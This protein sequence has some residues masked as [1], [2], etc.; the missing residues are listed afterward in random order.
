MYSCIMKLPLAVLTAF[1]ATA[2][3]AITFSDLSA[4]QLVENYFNNPDDPVAFRNIAASDHSCFALFADG[5]SAGRHSLTN[6]FLLPNDGLILS[7]GDPEDFNIND[8]DETTTDFGIDT[9]EIHLEHN[10][11]QGEQVLDPCFIQF[12]FSCPEIIDIYTPQVSFDYVFGSEEYLQKKAKDEEVENDK[13]INR[14]AHS[15]AL[16]FFLNGENIALVPDENGGVT[17]LS[18]E[19]VNEKKNTQY[20]IENK[21]KNTTSTFRS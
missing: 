17:S 11:A 2:T 6:Q 1:L 21:L 10:V 5:H 13:F 9:G 7:T 3:E 20:F 18:I 14:G 16:G 12:E 15:D 8:S 19:D 4:Q